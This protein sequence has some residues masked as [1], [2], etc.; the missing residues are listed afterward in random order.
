MNE[1]SYTILVPLLKDF[2]FYTGLGLFLLSLVIGF[3]LILR[4]DT[5]IQLNKQVGKKFSLRRFTRFVEVPNNIDRVLYR[6]HKIIGI[7][8]SLISAYVLYYFLLVYDSLA[9]AQYLK[10][11]ANP[12]LLEILMSTLRLFML[13]CSAVILMLG[14]TIFIRPSLIKIVE[15]WANR[16]I[17]TRQATRSLS[18]DRDQINQLA[19]KY[20]RLVGL[21]I[22]LLSIYAGILLF[23]VYT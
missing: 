12:L 19:Y 15:V 13:I 4:P 10:A 3:T 8:V 5:I 9:I 20:P 16:W 17:S 7:T 21:I 1:S 23:L 11:S 14:I 2:A 6:N 18:L 22:V